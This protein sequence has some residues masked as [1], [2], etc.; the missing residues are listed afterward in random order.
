MFH[1]HLEPAF[2]LLTAIRSGLWSLA[3]VKSYEIALREQLARLHECGPSTSFIIDI[4]STGAQ[5]K[6]VAIALRTMVAGLGLLHATR[7]AVVASSGIAKLQASRVADSSAKVFASMGPAR[8]WV[9][10]GR[11]PERRHVVVDNL[12]LEADADAKLVHVHG[13]SG[14][15]VTLTPAAALETAKRI[16]NAAVEA[17]LEAVS[18]PRIIE[19]NAH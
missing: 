17:L 10:G 5:P 19:V 8:I 16:G 12:A 15:D 7:T 1:F 2:P 3:T 11:A 18:L 9:M 13:A 6:D 4:R 14:V